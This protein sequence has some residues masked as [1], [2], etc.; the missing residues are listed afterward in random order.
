MIIPVSDAELATDAAPSVGSERGEWSRLQPPAKRARLLAAAS[1]VFADQ[2]LE[3]PMSEVAEVAGA[4]VASVYRLFPSKREL[5]A[6]L[7]A[8]RLNRIAAAADDA[9]RRDGDR[10]SALTEML[11]T[12][13]AD[14]AADDFIGEAKAALAEHAD[15]VA[16]QARATEALERLLAAGRAEGRLRADASTLDLRLL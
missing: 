4:G 6:A 14:Q 13:V 1:E 2:G 12:L 3:A 10:W 16:S 15:V 5:L 9:C 8:R 7:V 11:R